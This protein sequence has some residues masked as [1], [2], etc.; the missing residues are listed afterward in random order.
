MV[1]NEYHNNNNSNSRVNEDVYLYNSTD[2]EEYF[3]EIPTA[4]PKKRKRIKTE[5]EEAEEVPSDEESQPHG[6]RN[7]RVLASIKMDI[8]SSISKLFQ[9]K[10]DQDDLFGKMIAGELK[11][12][13][14]TLKYR[15]KHEI[16]TVIFNYKLMHFGNSTDV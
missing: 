5:N 8:M 11:T 10:S 16:S 9:E 13:P 6:T 4:P 3:P 2:D 15:V 14:E 7:K 1:E 12:F